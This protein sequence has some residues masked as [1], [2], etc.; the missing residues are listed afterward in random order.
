MRAASG[1]GVIAE[2]WKRLGK[3]SRLALV[4][5]AATAVAATAIAG[6]WLLRRDY[7]V[8]FADLSAQDSAAM[9]EELER[10]RIPYA[11]RE[12][13]PDGATTILVD[14]K[15]VHATRLKLM[16]KDLPLRSAV[17]FEL[18]N[19][20]DFGMT[21]FAQRINYQRA[22]QGELTRT[23][24]AL[25]EVRDARVLLA[26][27]EQGLFKQARTKATASITLSL[28]RGRTLTA[29]QVA[30]IQ[31]LVSAAVPGIAAADVTIVDQSG[32]ALT[33][34][35]SDAETSTGS[36]SLDL[37]R[38]TEQYLARKVDEVLERAFGRGQ[39]LAMVDVTL[40]MDRVQT[41]TEDVVPSTAR[42]QTG[43]VVR[44]RETV[45]EVGSP[46]S[47]E[48][49]REPV[50]LG[51]SA[52]R[53][54]EY[55]VGRR[56]AQ[57][58]GQPGTIRRLNVATVVRRPLDASEEA[59]IR[60]LV[61]AAAGVAF[62][63][64]D[65]VVIHAMDGTGAPANPAVGT[66]PAPAAEETTKEKSGGGAAAWAE[67]AGARAPRAGT[68]ALVAAGLVLLLWLAGRVVRGGVRAANGPAAL[69]EAE[70]SAALAQLQAWMRGEPRRAAG[71][72]R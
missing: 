50:P 45:R 61:A 54:V 29:A 19:D 20:S 2:T 51:G 15:D 36:T 62:E 28:K 25:S 38:D 1:A 72:G 65:T 34:P 16:S 7:Q 59:R 4:A 12:D 39:A 32:V 46:L 67:G 33:R 57:V 5:A 49:A 35:A 22:L 24:L 41:T 14:R 40:D 26:L 71:D 44:E 64:G 66:A 37:K 43:V 9:T 53:E 48:L 42:A 63:R 6:W 31:R 69:S 55:A 30:G 21:E 8:L 3:A 70:R 13:G 56:V 68:V 17:G 52:Q 60:N 23:I 11:L 58:V 10:Q 27:P 18:F 47:S